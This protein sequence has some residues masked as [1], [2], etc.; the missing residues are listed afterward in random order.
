MKNNMLRVAS[1]LLAATLISTCAIGG[2]F[3]KYV[4][5]DDVSDTARVAKFG[6]VVTTTGT[7]FD[8]KYVNQTSGNT[9]AG[10]VT[11]SLSVISSAT[12][13][14][15]VAPGTKN[16]NG[17]TFSITGTPEVA[18]KVEID[19]DDAALKDVF[20]GQ[21]NDLPDMTTGDAEDKF[22]NTSIYYPVQYTLT[23]AGSTLVDGG[24]LAQVSDALEAEVTATDGVY[25]PNTD[26]GQSFGVYTL[27]WEWP[28][29]A[30]ATA[31]PEEKT[32]Q[33]QQDTL[34]G[35]LATGTQVTGLT[36]GTDYNLTAGFGVT[37]TVTQVD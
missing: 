13:E 11:E 25:A 31:T 22:N 27:T 15:L 6:V 16:E 30:G 5:A 36:E 20:L 24:T 2:T 7:L 1:G 4:T 3:A 29:E 9:P 28:F 33:D 37:I 26:L 17:M 19:V 23:K 21:K 14:K 35:D 12:G 32:L 8:E 34:L 18:V 10:A